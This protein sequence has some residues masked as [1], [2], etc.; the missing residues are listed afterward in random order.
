MARP[1]VKTEYHYTYC[2]EHG[3]SGYFY[4]GVRTSEPMPARDMIYWGSGTLL[5]AAYKEQGFY[6][7]SPIFGMTPPHW[8]KSILETYETRKLANE[9]EQ[10]LI[11]GSIKN[12]LCLNTR[13]ISAD[14]EGQR[15]E[16]YYKVLM[17]FKT[18]YHQSR[19]IAYAQHKVRARMDQE[20]LQKQMKKVLKRAGYH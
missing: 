13:R 4:I 12:E 1:R 20:V 9:A 18:H 15:D 2:I 14:L 8:T 17:Y 10:W 5:N 19:T 6:K 11:D 16:F 3:P 7:D